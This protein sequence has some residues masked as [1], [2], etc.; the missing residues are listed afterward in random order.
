[1]GFYPFNA[2][3][4]L[5]NIG[6][7]TTAPTYRELYDGNSQPNLVRRRAKNTRHH[8]EP[9]GT[10]SAQVCRPRSMLMGRRRRANAP[11][12]KAKKPKSPGQ[13]VV[14]GARNHRELILLQTFC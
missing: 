12:A 3:R 10:N 13:Q 11:E 6:T 2:F 5:L 7:E 8:A 14:A 1:M 9:P 4:S